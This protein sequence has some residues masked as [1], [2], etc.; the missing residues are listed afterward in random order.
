MLG[1]SLFFSPSV[2]VSVHRTDL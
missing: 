2:P 1:S